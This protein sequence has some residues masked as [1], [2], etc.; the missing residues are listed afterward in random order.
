MMQ[1]K[2]ENKAQIKILLFLVKDRI[3]KNIFNINNTDDILLQEYYFNQKQELDKIEEQLENC[4][5]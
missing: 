4:H 5:E 2:L 1:I 3:K